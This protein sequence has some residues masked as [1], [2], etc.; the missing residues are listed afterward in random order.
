MP[1]AVQYKSAVRHSLFR[2]LVVPISLI[3]AALAAH[4]NTFV[5][6]FQFDDFSAVL[7]NPHLERWQTFIGHLDHMV[8]PVFYATFLM[9]RALYGENPV[10]YHL[11]N[12]LLHLGSGLL[13]YRIFTGAV[14]EGTLGLP[15][16]ASLLF[17]IHPVQ[18]EAVTYISGR[19]SGLMSFFYLMALF[20]YI[21]ASEAQDVPKTYRLY[22]TGATVSFIP[23]LGSKE[24]AMTFPLAVMLW[25][26]VIYRLRGA[27]LRAAVLSRHL[28]FWTVLLL[29]AGWALSHPRYSFLVQVSVHLR[30]VWENVLSEVHVMVYALMLFFRPWMQNFD[31]DLPV[32]HSL[33]QWPLPLDVSILGGMAVAAMFTLRRLPLLSFGILWFFIQLLPTTLVP[34]VDLFSERNL[35]LASIGPVLTTVVLASCL[36]QWFT[37]ALPNARTVRFGGYS[38]ALAVVFLLGFLTHQRNLVYRDQVSFWS[39]TVRKSP[40]K[41]R[42]HNNLGHAHALEGEWDEAIEEFRA[43]ARLDPNNALAHKNLRDAYLHRV[44][45]L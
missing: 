32:F 37:T 12:L 19:A 34:R 2:H 11:L 26:T 25:D 28:V 43:A 6:N 41:A 8:R 3:A 1:H 42:R 29:A 10:G 36:M 38:V 33:I 16:W 15:I 5:G 7:E 22:L 21:K 20:F 44:G 39:D 17:L 24:T 27:A 30:P 31:H 45:R 9:D 4:A 13:V 18:T 14:T 35:Y 40:N 23:S